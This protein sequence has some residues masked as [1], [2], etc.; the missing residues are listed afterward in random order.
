MHMRAPRPFGE[1]H[2]HIQQPVFPRAGVP[3]YLPPPPP[4][5]YPY[6]PPKVRF[7]EVSEE[8]LEHLRADFVD[9]RLD[10]GITGV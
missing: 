7:Y 6:P 9:G 1:P 4:A 8:E 3:L 10:I 5:L 2:T